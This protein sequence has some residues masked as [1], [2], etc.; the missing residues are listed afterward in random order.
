MNI[1]VGAWGRGLAALLGVGA[2]ILAAL[3]KEAWKIFLGAAIV[4]WIIPVIKNWSRRPR[5]RRR[6]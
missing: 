1:K 6:K 4:I 5:R 3:D 2:I